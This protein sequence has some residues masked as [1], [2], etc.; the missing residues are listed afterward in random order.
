VPPR[1]PSSLRRRLW[2]G[3]RG[4]GS[5]R[6]RRG[7]GSY[8]RPARCLNLV[9]Y[10]DLGLSLASKARLC[11]A[12]YRAKYRRKYRQTNSDLRSHLRRQLRHSIYL[13]LSLDLNLNLN[14]YLFL[15]FFQQLFT[16]LFGSMFDSMF[17]QL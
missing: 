10:L 13:D 14:L 15:R 7:I 3:S 5:D 12:K 8:S 6:F 11:L 4:A 2:R 1:S 17:V 16:T 9:P